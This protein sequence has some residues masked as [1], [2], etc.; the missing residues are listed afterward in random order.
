M[1]V[2]TGSPKLRL[3]KPHRQNPV[4]LRRKRNAARQG[5]V[6]CAGTEGA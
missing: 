2:S 3:A 6:W 4:A 5:Q 1:A